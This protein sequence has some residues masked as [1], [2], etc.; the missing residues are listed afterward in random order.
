MAL[1]SLFHC[2]FSLCRSPSL[3]EQSGVEGQLWPYGG[4]GSLC[5]RLHQDY[6]AMGDSAKTTPRVPS[7][8]AQNAIHTSLII[9]NI[10]SC[11]ICVAIDNPL[12]VPSVFCLTT[13]SYLWNYVRAADDVSHP[14]NL[15]S[16]GCWCFSRLYKFRDGIQVT[17]IFRSC[18]ERQG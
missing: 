14:E 5:K 9:Y 12:L 11:Q 18:G 13:S 15:K 7:T 17:L 1:R 16:N 2:F 3:N 6:N 4:M 10:P 8:R